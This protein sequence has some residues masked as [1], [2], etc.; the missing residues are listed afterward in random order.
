MWT[1][2]FQEKVFITSLPIAV[3]TEIVLCTLLRVTATEEQYCAFF[4]PQNR[5]VLLMIVTERLPQKPRILIVNMM[6]FYP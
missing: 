3:M 2:P 1:L 5:I 6:L 4:F